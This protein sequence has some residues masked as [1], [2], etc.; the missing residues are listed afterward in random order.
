MGNSF[1]RLWSAPIMIGILTAIGLLSALL[2]DGVWDWLSAILLAL[3]V[4]LCIRYALP[5]CR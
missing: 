5:R 3:P 1:M 4:F 2:G